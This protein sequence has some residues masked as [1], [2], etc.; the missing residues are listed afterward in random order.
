[1]ATITL[2]PAEPADCAQILAFI[3]GLAE[4][5]REPDAVEATEAHLRRTL[6]TDDPKVFGVM[7][8]LDGSPAGFAV[9][10]YNYSTWLGR[11]GLYLE[12]LYVDPARRGQGVGLA[13][14][15]HL[16]RTAV[17]GGCGRFEWMVLDWNEPAIEFYRAAGAVP[18]DEWTVYRLSGR[19]LAD[20]ARGGTSG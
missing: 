7:A 16:A 10:F 8:E 12:D 5:E 17:A 9:Y 18:M 1:M 13:L 4:Y 19:A 6:F 14:L 11:H 2:R 3:Q 20:F 15:R